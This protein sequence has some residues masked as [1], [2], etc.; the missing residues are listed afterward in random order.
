MR[1]KKQSS[2]FA[3]GTLVAVVSAVALGACKKEQPPPPPRPANPLD[4]VARAIGD[5]LGD[6]KA[7]V[8]GA[9]TDKRPALSP[10]EYEKALLALSACTVTEHGID[11]KCEAVKAFNA[12]KSSST[13]L[14]D[15]A[16]MNAGLGRKHLTNPSPAVRVMAA[17]L[18]GSFFGA[19]QESQTAVVAH[20]PNEKDPLVLAHLI[21]SVGSSSKR[22]PAVAELLIKAA[23]HADE[24]V[25]V[26]A[27]GW[28]ASSFARGVK[29]VVEKVIE[30]MQKDGSVKVMQAACRNVHRLEDERFVPVL[31]EL[32]RDPEASKAFYSDCFAGLVESW[33]AYMGNDAPSQKA[34]EL[35]LNR[36][37]DK[38]RS[39]ARPPWTV[40]SYFGKTPKGAPAWYK[41]ETVLKALGDVAA[42]PKANWMARTGAAE[43]MSKLGGTAELKDVKDKIEKSGEGD[44]NGK[45]YVLPKV[46]GYVGGAR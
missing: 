42:D 14:K 26:A 11:G 9:I 16:G 22:N 33:N 31:K 25:R 43:S 17:D 28:L 5:K 10:E 38:P 37:W 18:L 40:M 41:K 24:R 13:S 44:R 3:V 34:Y 30:K 1:T 15:F 20:A 2:R 32:T 12:A 8:E 27:I 29:G 45:S 4:Q 6:I 46:A 39:D 21:R 19:S 36:L 7:R 23:D 35:T